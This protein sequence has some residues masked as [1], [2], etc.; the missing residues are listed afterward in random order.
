VK[1][2]RVYFMCE[3]CGRIFKSWSGKLRPHCMDCD[4]ILEESEQLPLRSFMLTDTVSRK[5]VQAVNRLH[6]AGVPTD[7]EFKDEVY[8]RM[9]NGMAAV[10]EE[11]FLLHGKP[12]SEDRFLDYSKPLPMAELQRRLK[13]L[14]E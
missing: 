10:V 6:K 7:D 3:T 4:R 11:D 8:A 1:R 13:E 14:Y 5:F 2:E 9:R 12:D